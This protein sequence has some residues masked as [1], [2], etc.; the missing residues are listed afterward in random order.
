MVV[1]AVRALIVF[2][3]FAVF[4]ARVVV[5]NVKLDILNTVTSHRPTA[6]A[7][8]QG[9]A[10]FLHGAHG[11]GLAAEILLGCSASLLVAGENVKHPVH[12]LQTL[13][14]VNRN[15]TEHLADILLGDRGR[16]L[17]GCGLSGIRGTIEPDHRT[18]R[19][20]VHGHLR[21][22]IDR[23][24]HIVQH[25][26]EIIRGEILLRKDFVVGV[27]VIQTQHAQT[28]E[29]VRHR[30]A[31]TVI[32]KA[33][34]DDLSGG[35]V[36][37]KQPRA[38]ET[39]LLIDVPHI[40]V[41]IFAA[42]HHNGRVQ[43]MLAQRAAAD[44]A[45]LPDDLQQVA[46]HSVPYFQSRRQTITRVTIGR[47]LGLHGAARDNALNGDNLGTV[48]RPTGIVKQRFQAR[49]SVTATT[50]SCLLLC[51]STILFFLFGQVQH[52]LHVLQQITRDAP[53]AHIAVLRTAGQHTIAQMIQMNIC[54]GRNV[55]LKTHQ[56]MASDAL[57]AAVLAGRHN[58][59]QL[60]QQTL[61]GQ[62]GLACG[63]RANRLGVTD[64]PH[65][66]D[67]ILAACDQDVPH[68]RHIQAVHLQGLALRAGQHDVLDVMQ[69]QHRICVLILQARRRPAP[70]K[71]PTARV[72]VLDRG[73]QCR[74]GRGSTVVGWQRRQHARSASSVAHE[75]HFCGVGDRRD[76]SSLAGVWHV[77]SCGTRRARRGWAVGWHRGRTGTGGCASGFDP[78]WDLVVLHCNGTVRIAVGTVRIVIILTLKQLI[79]FARHSRRRDLFPGLQSRRAV[80]H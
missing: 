59:L 51:I 11:F 8:L 44:V 38:G 46:S 70:A 32:G 7:S 22:H 76:Q 80:L 14:A 74:G 58:G 78:T 40:D 21:A 13:L 41:A 54:N 64:T 39:L 60:L 25:D 45:D 15:L 67:A 18:Y 65:T 77:C 62:F 73:I 27:R 53:N 24:A 6:L 35:L 9:F 72:E 43:W 57:H 12:L 33:G 56:E 79:H 69:H 34:V 55:P 52:H 47:R 16:A 5:I 61:Q 20:F 28:A 2:T 71:Q 68:G 42:G 17:E 36:V 29:E 1:D 50:G 66:G 30:Q 37:V 19:G 10:L 48:G 26:I 23:K 31:G 49:A 3:I 4:T 75:L 63:V